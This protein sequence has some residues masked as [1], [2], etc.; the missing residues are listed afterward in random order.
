MGFAE[1]SALHEAETTLA[2]VDM[3]ETAKAY[4]F[5]GGVIYRAVAGKLFSDFLIRREFVGCEI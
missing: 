1:N 3:D 5:V 4:I 2:S